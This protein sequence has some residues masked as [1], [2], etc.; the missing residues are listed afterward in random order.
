VSEIEPVTALISTETEVAW[1]REE[2]RTGIASTAA[3]RPP[4]AAT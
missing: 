4:H 1:H 3:E 2:K